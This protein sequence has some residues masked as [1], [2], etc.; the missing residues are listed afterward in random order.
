MISC[1]LLGSTLCN[2]SYPRVPPI[3]VNH[4]SIPGI[5][6]T[7]TYYHSLI[8]LITCVTLHTL[9]LVCLVSLLTLSLD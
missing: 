8:D 2:Q 3:A 9:P 5:E 1:P 7:Y 4:I 6:N